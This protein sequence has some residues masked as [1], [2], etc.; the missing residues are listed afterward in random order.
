M[1]LFSFRIKILVVIL[2]YNDHIVSYTF[3]N[4]LYYL[5]TLPYLCFFFLCILQVLV[6]LVLESCYFLDSDAMHVIW[7]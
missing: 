3:R 2:Y 5:S 4:L 6:R 1:F 7:D